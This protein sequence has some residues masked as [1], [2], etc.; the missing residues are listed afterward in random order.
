MD[1]NEKALA[2]AAMRQAIK[3]AGGPTALA[4][5]LGISHASVS[6]WK[7]VPAE[8]CADVERITGVGRT[9]LR[10]DVFR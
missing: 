6:G 10:P 7:L 2:G 4:R 9:S 3:L 1:E 5:E 8:R